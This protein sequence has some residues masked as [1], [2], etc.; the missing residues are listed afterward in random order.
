MALEAVCSLVPPGCLFSDNVDESTPSVEVESSPFSWP[1]PR[2]VVDLSNG[3]QKNMSRK[4]KN[5]AL[6]SRSNSCL[7]RIFLMTIIA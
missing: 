4:V 5:A 3:E 6:T 2:V 7:S 1:F